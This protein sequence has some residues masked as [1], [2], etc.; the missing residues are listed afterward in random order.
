VRADDHATYFHHTTQTV[1]SL[2]GKTPAEFVT[3]TWKVDDVIDC[4]RLPDVPESYAVLGNSR[5]GMVVGVWKG[6]LRY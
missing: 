2:F 4:I 3:I 6:S 1:I 5:D